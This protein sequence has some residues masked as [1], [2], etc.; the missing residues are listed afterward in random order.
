MVAVGISRSA[1]HD[2][3]LARNN[4]ALVMTKSGVVGRGFRA[5]TRA[6]E[7]QFWVRSLALTSRAMEIRP[8]GAPS[9][10]TKVVP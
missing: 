1:R 9:G 2:K 5:L 10:T 6:E 8:C 7:N 3:N 4:G